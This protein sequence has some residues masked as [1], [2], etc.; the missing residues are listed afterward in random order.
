MIVCVCRA[1]SDR[2]INR[3]ID[4]G[5]R[6]LSDLQRAGIGD[7]CGSC[8]GM[9]RKMLAAARENDALIA[10]AAVPCEAVVLPFA[11]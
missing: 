5:A 3:I 11:Q 8:H 9:L 10:A 1:A 4:D 7:C 6:S 2:L